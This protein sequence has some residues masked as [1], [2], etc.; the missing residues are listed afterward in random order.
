ML[1]KAVFEV[2]DLIKLKVFG[3]LLLSFLFKR[4]QIKLG[5]HDLVFR[6][7]LVIVLEFNRGV[8]RVD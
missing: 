5:V 3:F 7:L 8:L 1:A 2:L 6:F 4:L